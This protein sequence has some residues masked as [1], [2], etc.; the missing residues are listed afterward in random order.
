MTGNLTVNVFDDS[1]NSADAK[2]V[3]EAIRTAV[4]YTTLATFTAT[5]EADGKGDITQITFT[6]DA[7]NHKATTEVTYD[8]DKTP[9][10][11]IKSV[12][13]TL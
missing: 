8:T 6:V 4:G 10:Y 13:A 12:T 9:K 2:K 3:S 5:F 7:D 1:S 11:P